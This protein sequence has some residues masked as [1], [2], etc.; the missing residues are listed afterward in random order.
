VLGRPLT[1]QFERAE[2]D[3]PLAA[4][5]GPPGPDDDLAGDPMVQ[6]VIELFEARRVPIRNED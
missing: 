2:A 1:V 3:P 6:K 4:V 5:G